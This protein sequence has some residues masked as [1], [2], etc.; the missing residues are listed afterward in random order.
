MN[1]PHGGCD[2]GLENLIPLLDVNVGKLHQ[3]IA[4]DDVHQNVQ[5]P[6]LLFDLGN[7]GVPVALI[8][9][10]QFD[11]M[12]VAPGADDFF[13]QSVAALTATARNEDGCPFPS[14][15]PG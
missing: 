3:R 2:I 6:G 11:E 9:Y 10:V 13:D 15:Q 1:S 8:N 7:S 4:A 5:S 14:E 12:R